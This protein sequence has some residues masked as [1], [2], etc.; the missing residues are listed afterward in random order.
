MEVRTAVRTEPAAHHAPHEHHRNVQ[1]GAARAAVFGI[2]DGLLTNV[3]LILGVAGAGPAPAVVRL[4]GLAGLVAGAFS[5]A[6]GEFVSMSAQKELLERELNLERRELERHPESETRELTAVFERRGLE[7]ADARRIAETIMRDPE[8]ALEVHAAEELGIRP[9]GTGSPR[10]AA[11]SSFV[12]FAIGAVITLLP[13]FVT[14]GRAAVIASIILGAV[15]A[16]L[17]GWTVAV[18]TGRSRPWSALRQ[19]AITAVAA[20]VTY[21]VGLAVGVRTGA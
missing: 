7:H 13:W 19:L 21:A 2:S 3:S 10:S 12:S 1:G 14:S 6:A 15:S 5:M 17:I 9:S 18:F 16:V 11:A 4:A 8:V 20:A